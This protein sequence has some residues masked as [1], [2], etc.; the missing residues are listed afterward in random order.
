MIYANWEDAVY[1][2]KRSIAAGELSLVKQALTHLNWTKNVLSKHKFPS[3]KIVG[4]NR[5]HT[6]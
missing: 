3:L 6:D 5:N 1:T 4:N 2:K